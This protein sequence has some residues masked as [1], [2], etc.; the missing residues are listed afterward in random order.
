MDDPSPLSNLL[1]LHCAE[2]YSVAPIVAHLPHFI[3]E[4]AFLRALC[5]GYVSITRRL[6]GFNELEIEQIEVSLDV[7]ALQLR[8]EVLIDQD[9]VRV[10]FKAAIFAK[11]F[12]HDAPVST[13]PSRL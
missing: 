1:L 6:T 5:D 9:K 4:F 13:T 2:T 12:V 11:D 8:V 3:H 7:H 10:D